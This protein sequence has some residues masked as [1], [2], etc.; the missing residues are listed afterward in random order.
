MITKEHGVA[1]LSMP[2]GI[3]L[4]MASKRTWS[5]HGRG[6]PKRLSKGMPTLSACSASCT[7]PGKAGYDAFDDFDS[8]VGLASYHLIELFFGGGGGSL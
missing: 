8:M 6:P 7:S 4:G 1:D 2:S 5:R 3:S